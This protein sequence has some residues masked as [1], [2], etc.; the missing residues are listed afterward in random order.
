[1]AE[2]AGQST[3]ARL[4]NVVEEFRQHYERLSDVRYGAAIARLQNLELY[5]EYGNQLAAAERTKDRIEAV[6]GAWQRIQE[7]AGL[8][9][10]P[11]IPIAVVLGLIAATSAT[12]LT[13]RVFMRRADIALAIQ[14]DPTLTYQEASSQVERS[15]QSTFGKAIDL[16]RVGLVLVGA[17]LFYRI[18][19]AGSPE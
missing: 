1:M 14:Q 13:M 5:T 9:A 11:L 8:A 10:L 19:R 17:F 15:Q 4:V 2:A 6:T 7:W 12:V 18:V 3:I 16:A